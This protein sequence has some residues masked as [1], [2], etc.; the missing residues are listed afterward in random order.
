MDTRLEALESMPLP[1]TKTEL[2]ERIVPARAALDRIVGSLSEA[3]LAAPG[4]G[5]GWAVKDHLTHIATWE[6]MSAALLCGGSDYE[7]VGMDEAT[8]E[9]QDI[10]SLNAAIYEM[11]RNREPNDVRTLFRDAHAAVLERLADADEATLQQQYWRTEPEQ[12]SVMQEL[13]GNTYGHY[14][15]HLRWI[16]EQI[17]AMP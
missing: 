5:G 4:P 14:L 15:Q 1:R 9:K 13:T 17:A 6:Q 10:D 12:R 3:Q 2:M 8:F 16:E 11:H 7:V